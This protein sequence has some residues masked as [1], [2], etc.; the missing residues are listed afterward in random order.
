[1]HKNFSGKVATATGVRAT[2]ATEL[3]I[4]THVLHHPR[5]VK[6][7]RKKELRDNLRNAVGNLVG[8]MMRTAVMVG[9]SDLDDNA[10]RSASVCLSLN[11]TI[12]TSTKVEITSRAQ[13]V[14]FL[15]SFVRLTNKIR[16]TINRPQVPLFRVTRLN[17]YVW[18]LGNPPKMVA[19]QGRHQQ[20]EMLL[21]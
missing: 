4:L 14:V 19:G 16:S 10:K 15:N 11:A 17:P 8:E 7:D 20:V 12:L 3:G 2:S 1:M 21:L 5:A 18:H 9:N 6:G 13:A